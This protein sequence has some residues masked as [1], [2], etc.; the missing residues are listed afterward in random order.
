MQWWQRLRRKIQPPSCY[1]CQYADA[2]RTNG[3]GQV[4]RWQVFCRSPDSPYRDRPIPSELHCP[5]WAPR[6]KTAP[7]IPDAV[8]HS[9]TP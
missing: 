1:T 3:D 8:H 2:F 6:P 9:P 4:S 7:P 5:A